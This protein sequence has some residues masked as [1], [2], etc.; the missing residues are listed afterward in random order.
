MKD[1]IKKSQKRH[2]YV[3]NAI[4]NKN[5]DLKIFRLSRKFFSHVQRKFFSDGMNGLKQRRNIRC[6]K[7]LLNL[8]WIDELSAELLAYDCKA[9]DEE[10]RR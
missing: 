3:S 7:K 1:F 9:L 6:Q 2:P 4:K 10:M 8:K 5:L